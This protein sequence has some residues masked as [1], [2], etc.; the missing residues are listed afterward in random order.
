[1]KKL[2]LSTLL[3]TCASSVLAHDPFLAPVVYHTENAQIPVIT[4]YTESALVPEYAIKDVKQI[5]VLTPNATQEQVETTLLKSATVADLVLKDKGTYTIAAQA[6]YPVK[7]TQ[8]NKQWKA[9]FDMS[10]EK[11]KPLAERDYVI[12][13]DFKKTPELVEIKRYWSLQSYVTKGETTP[14]QAVKDA[15]IQ[16]A[17]ST[18]PSQLT[19]QQD[20]ELS[21]QKSG[22]ALA[23]AKVEFARKGAEHDDVTELSTDAQGKVKLLF[24]KA[25]QYTIHV[26]EKFDAKQKAKPTDQHFTFINVEVN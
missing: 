1:M 22:K 4:S 23:N 21:V 2:V 19:A 16:V 8:H 24:P 17:F 3:F 9:F 12:P 14:V 5:Q 11:A 20:V 18:H 13:S 6:S 10:A 15:P 7:Y 26:G 25:G